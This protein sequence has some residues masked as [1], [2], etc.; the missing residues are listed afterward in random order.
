MNLHKQVTR[1]ILTFLWF[2]FASS[3]YA[4]EALPHFFPEGVRKNAP[5]AAAEQWEEWAR[6]ANATVNNLASEQSRSFLIGKS[7]FVEKTYFGQKVRVVF[8]QHV[9]E[10]IDS[11]TDK[12]TCKD[13][14]RT[15]YTSFGGQYFITEQRF[16]ELVDFTDRVVKEAIELDFVPWSGVIPKA[17]SIAY[18]SDNSGKFKSEQEFKDYLDRKDP[19]NP[20][21]T[22]RE[23]RHIPPTVER[24]DFIPFRELH[25]GLAPE[26]PSVLGVA[27]LNTGIVYYTP[28]AMIHDYLKGS[29]I[30]L[31]HEFVHTNK[32]LQGIPL[33]WGFNAETIASFP[34]M[35]VPGDYLNMRFHS[36]AEK[37]R[38]LIWVYYGF[39][40]EQANKEVI[41]TPL[42]GNIRIDRDKFN[43][44]AAKHSIAQAELMRAVEKMM[45]QFYSTP[46][47][48]T[49]LNDKLVDDDSVFE[50]MMASMYNPTL[51]G[52]E[53]ATTK[54]ALTNE[55]KLKRWADEAY[56]ESGSTANESSGGNA[57]VSEKDREQR[58]ALLVLSHIQSL[59][60]VS[61]ED[62][63]QFLKFHK[64]NSPEQLF[65]WGPDELKKAI[66]DFIAS[67]RRERR[68]Q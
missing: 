51:L 18:K 53:E 37:W 4:Q 68:V 36:Y 11:L 23:L 40:Y 25:I 60:G 1:L 26:I 19:L 17:I 28:V 15:R 38:K 9:C 61:D 31:A 2:G 55:Y 16:Q 43:E 50:V 67:Q 63:S 27:W 41:K 57:A 30:V 56:A 42:V 32:K 29:P 21:M 65:T 59:Y 54:W 44:Y 39:D 49:A 35:L 24:K 58:N 48:W 8:D 66:E 64:V 12:G 7:R 5:K 62:V 47:W 6:Y 20:S 22:F 45:E 34:A 52:G 14:D 13:G 10:T 33:V 3:A 46:V